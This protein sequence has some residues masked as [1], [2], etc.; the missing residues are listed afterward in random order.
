MRQFI[1]IICLLFSGAVAAKCER[2]L[3]VGIGT[4]WPPYV[5]YAD[6][7]AFGLDVEITEHVLKQAGLC[8]TFVNLPSSAR[9]INELEK[10]EVDILPSASFNT[11]RAKIAFFSEP[12]RRE[13]MRLF[14]LSPDERARN[15]QELFAADYIFT[16]NPGAYYGEE[17]ADILKIDWYKKRFFEVASVDRRMQ[18]VALGRVNYLI[19]DEMSGLYFVHKLGYDKIK[20]HSY[21]VNDNAI[22]FMLSRKTF[23]EVQVRQI[24]DALSMVLPTVIALQL[25]YIPNYHQLAD[26]D[27]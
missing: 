19:E 23:N 12:Y 2:T 3:K 15:L 18:M 11:E 22:H 21:V 8:F 1:V 20:L 4:E 7:R 17:L 25:K 16:A 5:M 9:G 6:E 26:K 10:G 27:Q 14:S 13:R 24:N